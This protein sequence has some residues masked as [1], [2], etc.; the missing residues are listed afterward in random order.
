MCMEHGRE[1]A[2]FRL[3]QLYWYYMGVPAHVSYLGALQFCLYSLC[4][5]SSELVAWTTH[6]LAPKLI[7]TSMP[8]PSNSAPV[9]PIAFLTSISTW[10]SGGVLDSTYEKEDSWFLL[11][12]LVLYFSKVHYN[13]PYCVIQMLRFPSWFFFPF[14][15]ASSQP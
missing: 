6:A 7:P 2:D 15:L 9:Y 10:N 5:I 11:A 12:N 8:A 13:S 14:Y 4:M 3:W 1:Q